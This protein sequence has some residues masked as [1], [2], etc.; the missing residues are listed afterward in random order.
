M[1]QA[2]LKMNEIIQ[3]LIFPML[4]AI[5]IQLFSMKADIGALLS[6]MASV[7][8]L[9]QDTH[10]EQSKRLDIIQWSRDH[11]KDVEKH[12]HLRDHK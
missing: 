3:K 9:A 6:Q 7:L 11:R 1:K 5:M 4:L 12:N 10:S 2:I 8:P